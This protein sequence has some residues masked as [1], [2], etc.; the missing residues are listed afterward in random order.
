MA[1]KGRNIL[2]DVATDEQASV[3]TTI[4]GLRSKT[5]V[6]ARETVVLD[7]DE[8]I[9]R[10][11]MDIPNSEMSLSGSGIFIDDDAINLME[12]LS[13]SGELTYFKL[14]FENGDYFYCQFQVSSFERTMSSNTALEASFELESHGEK[15]LTYTPP[16][17]PPIVPEPGLPKPVDLIL[18]QELRALYYYEANNQYF[19]WGTAMD[20]NG[21]RIVLSAPGYPNNTW[22]GAL[23]VRERNP[24]TDTFHQTVLLQHLDIGGGDD[25]LGTDVRMSLDGNLILATTIWKDEP[26]Q[27]AGGVYLWIRNVTTGA[28][29]QLQKILPPISGANDYFPYRES[30]ISADKSFL[31][32]CSGYHTSNGLTRNGAV[33]IYRLSG[34]HYIYDQT[35]LPPVDSAFNYFGFSAHA[36]A[37][38]TRLIIGHL[39]YDSPNTNAGAAHIYEMSGGAFVHVTSLPLSLDLGGTIYGYGAQVRISPDG[40]MAVVGT[41][42]GNDDRVLVFFRDDFGVWSK[43]QELVSPNPVN[44]SSY[45]DNMEISTDGLNLCIVDDGE[46]IDGVSAS[47]AAYLYYR[48]TIDDTTWKFRQRLTAPDHFA[49][50]WFGWKPVMNNDCTRILIGCDGWSSNKGRAFYFST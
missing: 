9:W 30:H 19:G 26:V 5:F 34:A 13:Q 44:S 18:R 49:Q 6:I 40:R 8:Y 31:I 35:I 21:E 32:L 50:Q 3:F 1:Y 11:L 2:I 29:A 23:S 43:T 25:S 7:T 24:L 22:K 12:D 33:F 45:S 42:F 39:F 10:K 38:G 17:V 28:W 41:I 14:T 47:G 48:D 15:S 36:S 16:T 4:G 27:N 37:D 46:T 20:Q